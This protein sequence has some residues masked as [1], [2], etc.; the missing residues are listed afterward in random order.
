M[1]FF[2][3]FDEKAEKND[4]F[5]FF[6]GLIDFLGKGQ[7]K[8]RLDENEKIRDTYITDISSND[9]NGGLKIIISI[10]SSD[11]DINCHISAE[12]HEDINPMSIYCFM[13]DGKAEIVGFYKLNKYI[14]IVIADRD[15]NELI[16]KKI[17][18]FYN[19]LINSRSSAS[20]I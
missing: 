6:L 12:H 10:I 4:W 7:F 16:E 1:N 19:K 20:K 11:A 9:I 14:K 3:I 8:W 18:N 2:A 13:E 15:K 5:N 17:R